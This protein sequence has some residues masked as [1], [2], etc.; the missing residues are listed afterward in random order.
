MSFEKTWSGDWHGR[1]L[2]RIR[3]LGF[4]NV[5]QY[6]SAHIGV[7]LL[8]LAA[9]LG[10]DDIA[11][12]Q[13]RSMLVDEAIRTN[14]V[15]RLLRDLFVRELRAALPG[16]WKHPLADESRSKVVGSLVRWEN[17]L[18]D[19]LDKESTFTAGQEFLDAELPDGWLPSDPDDP[20]I[21]TFVDHCLGR[22]PS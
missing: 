2:E 14:S 1:I 12:A 9:E 21:V 22:A 6:T 15:P 16:G 11:A 10:P 3:Q 20:I 5:T 8:V 13:I 17:S 7:S 18:K 19:H 4:E